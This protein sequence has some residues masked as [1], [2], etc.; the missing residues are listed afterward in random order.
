V[1]RR[2][3]ASTVLA[4][5][6]AITAAGC[7]FVTPAATQESYEPSDGTSADVGTVEI[8][9]ALVILNDDEDL[10]S[11]VFGALNTG[12]DAVTLDV[13]YEGDTGQA[14]QQLTIGPGDYVS[15]GTEPTILFEDFTTALGANAEIYFQYAGEPGVELAVPVLDGELAEY[16]GLVPTP[17]P[18]PEPEPEVVETPEP[19]GTPGATGTPTPEPTSTNG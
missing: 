12:S 15:V 18:T 19:T 9:N 2:L 1:K 13:S 6:V 7:A 10:A 4:A 17:T 16:A 14:S 5:G 11:L 3:V 8:V